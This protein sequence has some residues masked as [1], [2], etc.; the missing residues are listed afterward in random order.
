M[1]KHRVV[2]TGVG[3]LSPVGNTKEEFWKS[4]CEGRSGITANTAFDVTGYPSRIAG[5]VKNFD[6]SSI[7]KKDLRRMDK[8]V[9]LAVVATGQAIRD[10]GIDLDKE[11]R[12]RIGCIMGSG[13]GG[14]HTIEEQHTVLMQKGADRLSPFLI[15][16][17]IV[18][19]APGM[20]SIQYGLKGPNLAVA[21]ACATATHA[22]GEAFRHLQNGEADAIA[23]GG[24]ESALTPLGV[25]GFCAL[26]ALSLRNDQPQ[27]ASR[28]F[29]KERDGFVI[30]EGAG[31]VILETLENAKRRGAN[32]YC[33]VVGYSM[34]GDAYHMTSPSPDGEGAAR[35]MDI[36]IRDAGLR[37]DQ[38]SYINAHGTSTEYNDKFET[39]AIK[40]VFKDYAKKVPVSSTKSMTGHL[41]GA[42]GGI[43]FI[44]CAL[45]IRDGI[46]PP[47]INY[48][49]PDP[50]CDLDYVP[51][52]ARQCPVEIAMSNSLGFG[53]HNTS[54]V[55]KKFRG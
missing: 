7:N 29:D 13:I 44:A 43:E 31:I 40:T 4:L 24:T 52:T 20:V 12:N 10:A 8:F 11:D 50:A 14:I 34:T 48:E 39:M 45:A 22:I 28:P 55:V 27:R 3:V 6:V 19:M 21:T 1:S 41:L 15:P 38:I 23:C 35:C 46:I 42:A 47:T 2:L 26:R 37:P 16:M 17:L 51:N 32:I 9:Q 18:N 30:A 33:E 49:Y 25:G 36:A 5:Q 53:G 54:I